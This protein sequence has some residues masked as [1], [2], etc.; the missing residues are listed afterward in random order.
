MLLRS[1]PIRCVTKYLQTTQP[2]T[3]IL[4]VQLLL[5]VFFRHWKVIVCFQMFEIHHMSQTGGHT[6]QFVPLIHL[7]VGGKLIRAAITQPRTE[8]EDCCTYPVLM[9]TSLKHQDDKR[10]SF[11]LTSVTW[12]S[13]WFTAATTASTRAPG[14]HLTL[15]QMCRA[16]MT[17]RHA[18]N[19]RTP[20]WVFCAHAC[21]RCCT[22]WDCQVAVTME[23][24]SDELCACVLTLHL[25][26]AQLHTLDPRE[27]ACD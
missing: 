19:L 20:L 26:F 23:T 14:V 11:N 17:Q 22:A 3:C 1:A 16:P 15:A 10:H 4:L 9:N 18:E 21:A 8:R 5:S 13:G 25:P 2:I 7:C 6:N 12:D 27:A 24:S